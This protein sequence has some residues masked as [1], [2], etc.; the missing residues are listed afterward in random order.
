MRLEAY[1]RNIRVSIICPGFVETPL[2]S[3]V[4][5]GQPNE[6]H[7]TGKHYPSVSLSSKRCANI[8]AVAIANEISESWTAAQPSLFLTYV[9]FYLSDLYRISGPKSIDKK[10]LDHH[11]EHGL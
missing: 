9:G 1:H 2:F 8:I 3:K 11:W 10:A 6:I 5:S 4:F 7:Q